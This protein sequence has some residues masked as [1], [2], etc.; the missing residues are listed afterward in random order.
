MEKHTGSSVATNAG[1]SLDPGSDA[2]I[3]AWGCTLLADLASRWEPGAEELATRVMPLAVGALNDSLA[4]RRRGPAC[5][6]V[7]EGVS[8]A[9]M[10]LV[11]TS[12][13]LAQ[14]LGRAPERLVADGAIAF[15]GAATEEGAPEDAVDPHL[16]ELVGL[17]ITGLIMPEPGA[18]SRGGDA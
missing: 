11:E 18:E 1:E 5:P 8:Y 15:V 6:V 2:R 12:V 10:A 13:K 17:A 16:W 14:C 3:G 9:L 4:Q 7:D